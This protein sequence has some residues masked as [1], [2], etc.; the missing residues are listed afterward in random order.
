MLPRRLP[1]PCLL[2]IPALAA[3]APAPAG[4]PAAATRAAEAQAAVKNAF[5]SATQGPADIALAGQAH[6]HIPPDE[7]WVP[8]DA[9]RRLLRAWGNNPGPSTLGMVTGGQPGHHWAAIV[10][11]AHEGYVK[12]DQAGDLNPTDILAQLR[13]TTEHDNDARRSRGFPPLVLSGWVQPPVY[14]KATH[15]LVWALQLHEIGASDPDSGVNYNTRTLG[16][17]GYLSVNLLTTTSQFAAEKP[18][19]DQLLAGLTYDRGHR[20]QDFDAS[21]DHVAEIGLVG[22]L[23]VV[24]AQKLGMFALATAFFLKFAKLGA[25]VFVAIVAGVRRLLRRRPRAAT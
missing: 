19:A 4:P 9:A 6:L 7:Q 13:D 5:A 3:A 21:T 25:V 15:R 11:Y 24:V 14:N 23:G 2:L 12:D 16:R 8:P 18:L 10:T 22:L 17:E 20:Y 1:L